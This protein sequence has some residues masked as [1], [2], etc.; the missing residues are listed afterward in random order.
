MAKV[1]QFL[2][3]AKF[4]CLKESRVRQFGIAF[5]GNEKVSITAIRE[6]DIFKQIT[7]NPNVE[8]FAIKSSLEWIQVSGKVKRVTISKLQQ[9]V[10]VNNSQFG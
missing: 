10:F 9:K 7:A 6:K 8:I 5:D 3:D 1:L 4:L 2:A